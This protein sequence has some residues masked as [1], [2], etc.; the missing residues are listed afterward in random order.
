MKKYYVLI[1]FCGLTLMSFSQEGVKSTYFLIRHAEKVR[2]ENTTKDPDLTKEGLL[3]AE[4]W[5]KLFEQF[6]IDAIYSTNYKR[7][8]NTAKPTAL[9]KN[10]ETLVYHPLK[11]DFTKFLKD[12]KGK[13]VV[14]VGHSNTIPSFANR[15]IGEDIY[16]DIEDTNN[17]NLYIVTINGNQTSH[18]LVKT[19]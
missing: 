6:K 10:I 14:I 9:E 8:L 2:S 17:A 11:I 1:I 12:T 4:N 3:R 18:V 13:N 7:T 16:P 19:K 15:I 5:S